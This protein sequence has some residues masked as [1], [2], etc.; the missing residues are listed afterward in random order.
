MAALTNP[1]A[2]HTLSNKNTASRKAAVNLTFSYLISK[3]GDLFVRMSRD[4]FSFN[5]GVLCFLASVCC[6]GFMMVVGQ[7][8]QKKNELDLCNLAFSISFKL[9]HLG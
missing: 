3:C 8:V 2:S 9:L 6:K 7:K 1:D 4:I 5:L